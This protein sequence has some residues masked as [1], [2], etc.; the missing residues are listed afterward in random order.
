MHCTTRMKLAASA[1]MLL[2]ANTFAPPVAADVSAAPSESPPAPTTPPAPP[3][4]RA[5]PGSLTIGM[6]APELCVDAWLKGTPATPF[7]P[8]TVYIVEFWASWCGPC[9]ESMT[10]LSELQTIYGESRLRVV[11]VTSEDRGNSLDRVKTVLSKKDA[12]TR[13]TIAWDRARTT[14]E[15]YMD[16]AGQIGIP[17]SFIVNQ[18]GLIA[19][20]GSPFE[21]DA[22][23]ARILNRDW[24]LAAARAAFEDDRAVDVGRIVF[25][26]SL[27]TRDAQ[28]IAEAATSFLALSDREPIILN[29]VAHSILSPEQNLDFVRHP[30]L[31]QMAA[32]S[33]RRFYSLSKEPDP[34]NLETLARAESL[35]GN[36]DRAI[37][38]QTKAIALT[39]DPRVRTRLETT[40]KTYQKSK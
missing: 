23:L 39:E 17:T 31:L 36:R 21:I 3:S 8:G 27:E 20:V 7:A 1:L 10:H 22:P 37:E 2:A 19:W 25:E 11:G 15:T 4:P 18:D 29:Y 35:L 40:L 38:L 12:S 34:M 30:P 13:Y 28:K 6:P 24:D 16:A 5:E 14:Y 32:D 26:R 9:L 33:A